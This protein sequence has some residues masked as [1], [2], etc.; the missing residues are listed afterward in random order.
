MDKRVLVI[1]DDVRLGILYSRVLA[2][3][4]YTVDAVVSDKDALSRAATG[5]YPV[6]IL[7]IEMPGMSGLELIHELKRVAPDMKVVLNSAY[8]YFKSDFQS[9]LAD[10][11]V[12]KSSDLEPLKD[13]IVRLVE[14]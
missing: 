5:K 4:G 3:I 10:A 6:A 14:S 12:V 2:E 13:T 7:D 1:D 8:S 9:W 11:Y